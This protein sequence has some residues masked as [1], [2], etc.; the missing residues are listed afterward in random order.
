M[1]KIVD[2]LGLWAASF[3]NFVQKREKA[4]GFAWQPLDYFLTILSIAG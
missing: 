1:A 2:R 3:V 4:A